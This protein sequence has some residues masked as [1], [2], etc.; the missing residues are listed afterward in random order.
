M[1]GSHAAHCQHIASPPS[2][3]NDVRW[4]S[5]P[6]IVLTLC[7]QAVRT[8]SM[9]C[10]QHAPAWW[11]GQARR[12]G[13]RCGAPRPAS[14]A[15]RQDPSGCVCNGLAVACYHRIQSP[16]L[17]LAIDACWAHDAACQDIQRSPGQTRGLT[18]RSPAILS[19]TRASRWKSNSSLI[20]RQSTGQLL[21]LLQQLHSLA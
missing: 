14:T 12:W 18:L 13:S 3:H 2:H 4:R 8:A 17:L 20:C 15:G 16:Q 7:K 10:Q 21:A 1:I 19:I 6:N 11:S 9:S 5:S